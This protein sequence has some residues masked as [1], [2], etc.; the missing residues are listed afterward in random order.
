MGVNVYIPLLLVM[1]SNQPP[2]YK[3][4]PF[5]ISHPKMYSDWHQLFHGSQY[6]S[7]RLLHEI[8]RP[9]EIYITEEGC[10]GN[11]TVAADGNVY[12]SDRLTYL[13]N[14]MM[15]QKRACAEGILLKGNFY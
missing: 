9:K 15:W 2:G 4:V 13:R 8:W 10:A 1:A 3:E 7:P 5:S 11:D 14:G 12:D 6:W